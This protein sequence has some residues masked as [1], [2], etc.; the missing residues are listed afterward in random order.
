MMRLR[1]TATAENSVAHHSINEDTWGS[2]YYHDGATVVSKDWTH[3]SLN[4]DEINQAT[5]PF[6]DIGYLATN[7]R[8]SQSFNMKG[9][10][11]GPVEPPTPEVSNQRP[12]GQI[13]SVNAAPSLNAFFQRDMKPSLTPQ[14]RQLNQDIISKASSR[15]P[16]RRGH[17][18][19]GGS[20][21]GDIAKLADITTG[22]N[23]INNNSDDD[24]TGISTIV[25]MGFAK[26]P[27]RSYENSIL[28]VSN[29]SNYPSS[30]SNT[31][32][33]NK[34]DDS[35]SNRTRA[36]EAT[37][38]H[39]K[40]TVVSAFGS[41][42]FSRES[43]KSKER[44]REMVDQ[45]EE[46]NQTL[47]RENKQL[48]ARIEQ[49]AEAWREAS[50]YQ[51]WFSVQEL[52]ELQTELCQLRAFKTIVTQ[53]QIN[54]VAEMEAV[55]ANLEQTEKEK[56]DILIENRAKAERIAYLELMLLKNQLDPSHHYQVVTCENPGNASQSSF[57]SAS[58][59]SVADQGDDDDQKSYE[60]RLNGSGGKTTL[61]AV[62]DG[63]K[64]FCM[65]PHEKKNLHLPLPPPPPPSRRY[66]TDPSNSFRKNSREMAIC[67]S[68]G[69]GSGRKSQELVSSHAACVK[70]ASTSVAG[71]VIS[72]TRLSDNPRRARSV[73]IGTRP[74]RV[75]ETRSADGARTR[76]PK[77]S[78][79]EKDKE[80]V[81]SALTKHPSRRRLKMSN[82]HVDSL[83][84]SQHSAKSNKSSKSSKSNKSVKSIRSNKSSGAGRRCA[85]GKPQT[86]C[87]GGTGSNHSTKSA[88][89]RRL[90][91]VSQDRGTVRDALDRLVGAEDEDQQVNSCKGLD[92]QFSERIKE[93][94]VRR[95]K[96]N[97]LVN[98]VSSKPIPIFQDQAKINNVARIEPRRTTSWAT[99]A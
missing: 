12:N 83:E 97:D 99:S 5:S 10:N 59:A 46:A 55:V 52:A 54:L 88:T 84:N 63:F 80:G 51:A 95:C 4:S 6:D 40:L 11:D 25:S 30:N 21:R 17:L 64:V 27:T 29:V 33:T 85:I 93:S 75:I 79:N 18:C 14:Q 71:P 74:S 90:R 23:I 91:N 35:K 70:D 57:G 39:T 62:D 92:Q 67:K 22:Y 36:T 47:T 94:K 68:T 45:L 8:P 50:L 48:K 34:N 82:S 42:M 81:L 43:S 65:V 58:F 60:E 61:D 76:R 24:Y 32:T 49:V 87:I 56:E 72:T 9:S 37:S 41:S 69:K 3:L 98:L 15:M 44:L 96:S 1:T 66:L 77:L 78:C 86:E 73:S 53:E 16:F 31:N 13:D 89:R 2:G 28:G 38:T 20:K 19:K 7:N 26:R